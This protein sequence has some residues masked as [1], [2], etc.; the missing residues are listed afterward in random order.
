VD[1]DSSQ[2]LELYQKAANQ[3]H[4]TA[5][6]ALAKCYQYGLGVPVDSAKATSIMTTAAEGCPAAMVFLARHSSHSSVCS[7]SSCVCV[8]CVS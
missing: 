6:C 2:T 3:G 4:H 7:V 1:V 5:Q 8:L